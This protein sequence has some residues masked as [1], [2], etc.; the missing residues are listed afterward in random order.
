MSNN[1]IEFK[2]LFTPGILETTLPSDVY[3]P[4][5]KEINKIEKN[6][7][8][9]DPVNHNLAGHIKREYELQ[10]SYE[11]LGP[12]LEYLG[13]QYVTHYKMPGNPHPRV[14]AL[15]C[16]FQSKC[17]INPVHNHSGILSFAIWMKIPYNHDDEQERDECAMSECKSHASAFQFIYNDIVGNARNHTI[18]VTKGWE[19]KMVMFPAT[20]LHT[21]YPFYTSDD[22]RVSIAGNLV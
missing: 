18:N 4:V 15:W 8:G 20:L 3:D 22:Y 9:Y 14:N 5:L 19:G 21:V 6:A 7:T 2:E 17:E 16:N 10:E 1:E 11:V 12:Y 13:H